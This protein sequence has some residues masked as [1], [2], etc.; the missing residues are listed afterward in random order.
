MDMEQPGKH[1]VQAKRTLVRPKSKRQESSRNDRTIS[2]R[3]KRVSFVQNRSV[4]LDT[5]KVCRRRRLHP[6]RT[7]ESNP[8]PISI[9]FPIALQQRTESRI[10]SL[11]LSAKNAS[12]QLASISGSRLVA[13]PRKPYRELIKS[14]QQN[15]KTHIRMNE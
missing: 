5:L 10:D 15:H 7:A 8:N 1:V 4:S 2:V 13:A 14:S 3:I 9:D 12:E 11:G 6:E